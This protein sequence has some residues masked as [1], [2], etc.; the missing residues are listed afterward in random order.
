MC[1]K[2]V[3]AIEFYAF[4]QGNH[5]RVGDSDVIDDET[6]EQCTT[7]HPFRNHQLGQCAAERHHLPN[8]NS[9]GYFIDA[10]V[11]RCHA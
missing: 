4:V 2:P 5:L 3:N 10:E 8:G 7:F 1:M 6:G 9:T 11:L